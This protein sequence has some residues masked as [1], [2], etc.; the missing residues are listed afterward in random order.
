MIF[1]EKMKKLLL[2]VS[3]FGLITVPYSV[4]AEDLPVDTNQDQSQTD[5]TP[6]APTNSLTSL[7]LKLSDTEEKDIDLSKCT[8]NAAGT[9]YTCDVVLPYKAGVFSLV[10]TTDENSAV[11]EA[12]KGNYADQELIM[13]SSTYRINLSDKDATPPVTKV[14]YIVNVT[15]ETVKPAIDALTIKHGDTVL[16]PTYEVIDGK[17][18]YTL[19]ADYTVDKITIAV[20]YDDTIF[21]ASYISELSMTPNSSYT[22]TIRVYETKNS[23]NYVDYY[24]KLS[25]AQNPLVTALGEKLEEKYGDNVSFYFDEDDEKVVFYQYVELDGTHIEKAYEVALAADSTADTL[26]A[27]YEEAI[28]GTSE[29][30]YVYTDETGEITEPVIKEIANSKA[31]ATVMGN[32]QNAYW[33]IDGTKLT[34]ADKGFNADVRVDDEVDEAL[35]AKIEKLLDKKDNGLIIDFAHDGKLPNG[36]K[37]IIYVGDKEYTDQKYNL[38]YYNEKAGTLEL[39]VKNVKTNVENGLVESVELELDHCSS[40]VLLP[41]KNNAKT[42]MLDVALYSLVAGASLIGMIALIK[43]RND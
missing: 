23:Q 43:K 4:H 6:A 35:R 41:A 25:R 31:V 2:T 27:A 12:E 38:Y 20:D 26:L 22:P 7:K 11:L 3:L 5:V 15:R 24:L 37:V 29:G 19:A 13:A 1:M 21:S 30:V 33:E 28:K 16:T 10:P 36:T 32:G 39:V 40:Y 42:G 18:T 14:T 8:K 34:A 9:E 17:P